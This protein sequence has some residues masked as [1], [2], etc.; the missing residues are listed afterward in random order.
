MFQIADFS[1]LD[2]NDCVAVREALGFDLGLYFFVELVIV[3][4]VQPSGLPTAS[5]SKLCLYFVSGIA[6]RGRVQLLDIFT[7]FSRASPGAHFCC[8]IVSGL[9]TFETCSACSFLFCL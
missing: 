2:V 4:V 7:A 6:S 1:I 5:C 9:I 8:H 3:K